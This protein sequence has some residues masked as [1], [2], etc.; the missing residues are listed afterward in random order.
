MCLITL[1]P[2]AASADTS[3]TWST[4]GVKHLAWT[5]NYIWWSYDSSKI[6]ASD[7]DQQRSGLFVINRGITKLGSQSTSTK[8]VFNCKN[9]FLAGAELGGVT[10][11]WAQ[12]II[13]QARVYVSGNG[14]WSFDI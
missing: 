7:T 6:I 9:E 1:M 12:T 14:Y 2:A 11:G 13:D 5:K 3:S 8:W 10:L 4:R